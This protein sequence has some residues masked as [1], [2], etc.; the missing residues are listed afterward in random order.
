MAKMLLL[1]ILAAAVTIPILAARDPNPRRGFKRTLVFFA[2][3]CFCYAIA[4]KFVYL[5]LL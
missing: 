5:K 4:L 2:V 3:Y 1:S